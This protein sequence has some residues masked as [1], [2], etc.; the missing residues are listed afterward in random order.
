VQDTGLPKLQYCI[1][2]KN[3]EKNEETQKKL[4]EKDMYLEGKQLITWHCLFIVDILCIKFACGKKLHKKLW[5]ELITY[6]PL[7]R[8][9]PHIKKNACNSPVFVCVF[10]AAI[11]LLP[12][13]CLATIGAYTYRH[14]D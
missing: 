10:I 6:F 3:R 9:G 5:E 8:H 1:I 11:T 7:I 14:T 13:H 4:E 2:P 12:S